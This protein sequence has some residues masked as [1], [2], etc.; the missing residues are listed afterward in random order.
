[1]VGVTEPSTAADVIVAMTSVARALKGRLGEHV[2]DTA[3]YVLLH[4]VGSSGPLRLTELAARVGLD[5]STVSRHVGRLL[6]AGIVSRLQ[7][8]SDR[9]AWQVELTPAGRSML[10]DALGRRAEVLGEVFAS[11]PTADQRELVRLLDALAAG[12]RSPQLAKEPV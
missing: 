12:L 7:D 2:D 8:T 11:W 5:H 6:D 1:M 3:T 9:R 10:D 4:H